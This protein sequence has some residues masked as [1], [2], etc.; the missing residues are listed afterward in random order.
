MFMFTSLLCLIFLIWMV[1]KIWK[2]SV[3]LAIAS[4]LFWPA[5]IFALFRYWGDE[6][7]DIKVPFVLF[8][9][10]SIYTWYSMIQMG[11]ALQEEQETLLWT[12]R[13]LA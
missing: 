1:A 4:F 3:G 10:C 5:L 12:L 9:I 8:T 13:Q 7:S 6:E 11:K 2:Q